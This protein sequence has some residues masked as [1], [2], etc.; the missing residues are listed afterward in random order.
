M[1]APG[2]AV[3]VEAG[4]PV[5]AVAEFVGSHEPVRGVIQ[6]SSQLD[7]NRV[8]FKNP[9]VPLIRFTIG[10]GLLIINAHDRRHLW[11]AARVREAPGFPSS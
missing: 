7:L 10:T 3:P 11:Q 9:F 8:R 1:K 6:A 4:D 2:K 5:E